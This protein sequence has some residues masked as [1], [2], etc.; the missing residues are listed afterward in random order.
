MMTI[1]RRLLAM[2]IAV[3]LSGAQA[4][5]L[6]THYRSDSPGDAGGA[7]GIGALGGKTVKSIVIDGIKDPKQRKNARA[8]LTLEQVKNETITQP[9]YID[10]LIRKGEK[11]IKRSQ[12]PFGYYGVEVESRR[13]PLEGEALQIVYRVSLGEAVAIRE[14]SL[15]VSGAGKSDPGF[16]KLLAEEPFRKDATF[17]HRVYEDYKAKFAAL[18][19][20]RGY[21]DGRFTASRVVVDPARHSADLT[22]NYDTGERYRF[23]RL[24]FVAG[25][26]G[27]GADRHAASPGGLPLDENFLRRFVSFHAGDPYRLEAVTALQQDLQ[28]SGYFRQVL[29]GGKPD[30]SSRTVPT[31]ARLTMNRNKHYAFGVGYSTDSGVHGKFAFDRR[32]VNSHGH[33]LSSNFYLSRKNSELDTIYRIPGDNPTSDYA[34]LRLGGWIREDRYTSHRA[35]LEGGY[36][37]RRKRWEYRLS[38]TTAYEKFAIGNDRDEI[39]LSYPTL[40]AVYTS[41]RNRLNPAS[42]FQVRANVLG[43]VENVLSRISLIQSNVNLRYIQTLNDKNRVI[44]RFDGGANWTDDFH[45]LP[46]GLRYFAGGDRSI[47]GYAYRNI[48]PRDGSGENIGG[49]YLALGTLEYEYSLTPSLALAAF[50]DGGDAFSRTFAPKY[51]AGIG[52]HWRSPVGPIRIDLGHGFAEKYGDPLR[53]HLTVG[54]ELDL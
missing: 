12:Q 28:G 29:V 17:D 53:L 33:T 36:D 54:A 23:E 8:F 4:R 22:L 34:Y 6:F 31:E 11:E 39:H 37:W 26:A 2:I 15:A 50:V 41:T 3:S 20:D 45:R 51:G 30:R 48:G 21:F 7:A 10:Y 52:L 32:W 13:L 47:R 49:K 19:R 9:G 42:G 38:G 27:N 14:I 35:F 1:R 46:P 5:P 44:A 25:D 24:R 43:G 40:Q 18:S 16:A